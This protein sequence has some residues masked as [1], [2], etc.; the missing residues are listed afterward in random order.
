[1]TMLDLL[2]MEPAKAAPIP[3]RNLLGFVFTSLALV[4]SMVSLTGIGDD[5]NLLNAFLARFG[6]AL[7]TT[8][9]GL[10]ARIALINFRETAGDSLT[11]AQ[12]GLTRATT[13]F[14]NQLEQQSL[15]LRQ[16]EEALKRGSSHECMQGE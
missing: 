5:P 6:V 12:L 16:T 10:V 1:M 14:K 8:L 2:A 15:S 13:T 7:L 9:V 4:V 3:E 11:R